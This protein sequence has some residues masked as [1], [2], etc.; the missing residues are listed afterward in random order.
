MKNNKWAKKFISVMSTSVVK[1][2]I[3]L[4]VISFCSIASVE[5]GNESPFQGTLSGEYNGDVMGMSVWGSFTLTISADGTVSGKYKGYGDG[6]ISGSVS[7]SGG[8]NAKG[9]A[10]IAEWTGTI[11][12]K[13]G[14]LAAKG[15]WEGLSGGG[16]WWSK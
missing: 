10:E 2:V 13:D 6:A 9:S 11:S 5:G 8:I 3:I 7:K 12:I 16:R 1:F 15:T 4:T 14:R